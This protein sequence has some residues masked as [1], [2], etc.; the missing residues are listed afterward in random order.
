LPPFRSESKH[1]PVG[2][3][4]HGCHAIGTNQAGGEILPEEQFKPANLDS[5]D[6]FDPT[7]IL[8]TT[9]S[10]AKMTNSSPN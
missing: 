7:G 1:T 3:F 4:H 2:F 10:T 6:F 5:E 9:N 8:E